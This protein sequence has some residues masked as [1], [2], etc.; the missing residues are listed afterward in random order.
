MSVS[1]FYIIF[2]FKKRFW[3]SEKGSSIFNV[4]VC[5]L[6]GLKYLNNIFL[7]F[8]YN[9]LLDNEFQ[10]YRCFPL[11]LNYFVQ[12]P[13]LEKNLSFFFWNYV[14]KCKFILIFPL[15][16]YSI[17]SSTFSL[18]KGFQRLPI[19]WIFC[20]FDL[21]Y[22]RLMKSCFMFLILYCFFSQIFSFHCILTKVV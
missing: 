4:G 1:C 17:K 11:S 6:V 9:F 15:C 16:F 14:S 7:Q 5:L 13:A 12:Q 3:I 19:P 2:F 22:S 8:A 10:F 18:Y 21:R 20:Y